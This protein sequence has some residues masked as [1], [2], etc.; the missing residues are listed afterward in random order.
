MTQ[1]WCLYCLDMYNRDK[2]WPTQEELNKVIIS[3]TG[4]KN[5]P[6][7]L[8]CLLLALLFLVLPTFP[9]RKLFH[10]IFWNTHVRWRILFQLASWGQWQGSGMKRWSNKLLGLCEILLGVKVSHWMG[11]WV[12]LPAWKFLGKFPFLWG[13]VVVIVWS[14]LFRIPSFLPG[15]L[16]PPPPAQFLF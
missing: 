2:V 3:F 14:L 6:H 1:A 7:L 8:L 10:D 11:P 4:T 5:C 12:L 9:Q 13:F 16:Q 15:Q